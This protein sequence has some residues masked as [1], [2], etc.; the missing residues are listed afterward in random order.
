MT[1]ILAFGDSIVQGFWDKEGGWVQRL[2]KHLTEISINN[3]S[4]YF[5]VFN[6]GVSGDTSK[7][8]LARFEFETK[9]RLNDGEGKNDT[10]IIF[11]IGTNDSIFNNKTKLHL[12][13][14]EEYRKN[15]TE[16]LELAKKYA[17]KVIFL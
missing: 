4:D 8:L 9:N 17:S 5:S 12:I 16:L 11:S 6:L 1:T 3:H 13:S 2:K 10:L 15:L 7:D 14:Q